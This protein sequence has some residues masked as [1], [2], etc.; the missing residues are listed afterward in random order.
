[1]AGLC[2]PGWSAAAATCRAPSTPPAPRRAKWGMEGGKGG[3][4]D[5]NCTQTGPGRSC[6]ANRRPRPG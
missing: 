4:E 5:N 3:R 2:L 1:M 6:A